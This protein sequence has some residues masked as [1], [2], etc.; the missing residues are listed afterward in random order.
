MDKFKIIQE[1]DFGDIGMLFSLFFK[2]FNISISSI[3][4]LSN[5]W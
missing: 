3:L 5:G 1:S 2:D 4:L